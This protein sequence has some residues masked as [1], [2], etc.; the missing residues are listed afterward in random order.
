VD[1]A[2][3]YV[4]INV[5]GFPNRQ[6][7]TPSVGAIVYPSITRM[8]LTLLSTALISPVFNLAGTYAVEGVEAPVITVNANYLSIDMSIYHRSPATGTILD[9]SHI[10]VNFPADNNQYINI[11]AQTLTAQLQPP[12]TLLWSNGTSWLKVWGPGPR[13][14]VLPKAENSVDVLIVVLHCGRPNAPFKQAE[15][16]NSVKEGETSAPPIRREAKRTKDSGQ[17]LPGERKRHGKCRSQTLTAPA[18]RVC[19]WANN[20]LVAQ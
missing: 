13:R 4:P 9:R 11:A 20:R 14:P 2:T 8:Y 12:A 1:V 15:K 16:V 19:F 5:V 18:R 6:A 3:D 10:V 17:S 7:E